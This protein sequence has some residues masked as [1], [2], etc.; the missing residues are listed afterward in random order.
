M[1]RWLVRTAAREHAST[2]LFC[3]PHAGG[4]ASLYRSWAAELPSWIDPVA[5]QL[6]GRENRLA[7][8]PFT[9]AQR[10]TE[11]IVDALRGEL[12]RPYALFGHSMGALL[13]FEAARQLGR[14]GTPSPTRLFVAGHRAPHCPEPVD[15]IHDL[16]DDQFIRR[17]RH[18]QGTP[19]EIFD[20]PSLR[21]LFLP[22]LR[23]DFELCDGYS[24]RPGPPLDCPVTAVG[25][26]SDPH[27]P[28]E[29]LKEWR[30]LTRGPFETATVS[31]GHFFVN[32][33]RAE[34]LRV[35][36]AGLRSPG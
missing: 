17:V 23:A 14:E 7:E 28:R 20:E 33:S 29:A 30:T 16:P 11:A 34:L 26:S 36:V 5:V 9:Q 3:L 32:E 6:P 24:F 13:A 18:L 19:D 35:V 10:A 27:V 4:G 22:L 15:R 21:E 31:G 1:S 12:D 8:A 2:R 25:G